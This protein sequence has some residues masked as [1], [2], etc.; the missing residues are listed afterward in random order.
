MACLFKGKRV[1]S[2][3]GMETV[4]D[5]YTENMMLQ[6]KYSCMNSFKGYFISLVVQYVLSLSICLP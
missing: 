2:A 6:V 5:M 4:N 1:V 3:D